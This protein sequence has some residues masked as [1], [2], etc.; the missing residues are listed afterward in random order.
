MCRW[1]VMGDRW[2]RIREYSWLV[3]SFTIG[4]IIRRLRENGKRTSERES[5]EEYSG[6]GGMVSRG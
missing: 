4:I 5:R 1:P 2:L 6:I 3:K